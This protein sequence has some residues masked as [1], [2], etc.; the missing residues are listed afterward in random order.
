MSSQKAI[1]ISHAW[2]GISDEI[3]AELTRVLKQEDISF[4]LDKRDLG[5]RQSINDFMLEL[6][7]ADM[8]IIILSNKYLKS[9]YCM[10]ELIQIY[11]NQ[12]VRERIFPIVLD[13]VKISSSAD[14]LEFV[15]YWEDQLTNLQNKVK[16]LN[17]LSYIEGITDDLNLYTEIRNNI[18]RLT[19]ILRDINTL[20][21]TIHVESDYRDLI[22]SI[23]KK[24]SGEKDENKIFIS[25]TKTPS[26]VFNTF[27]YKLAGI[28]MLVFIALFV[29]WK[30]LSRPK[31]L[32]TAEDTYQHQQ[33]SGLVQKNPTVQSPIT[34][35]HS[36]SSERDILNTMDTSRIIKMLLNNI[37]GQG[38]LS[39]EDL[40]ALYRDEPVVTT[41]QT[42]TK[43]NKEPSHTSTEK[44]ST[45]NTYS[46]TTTSKK[47]MP[48]EKPTVERDYN[49]PPDNSPKYE[50]PVKEEKPEEK[51]HII[52][53]PTEQEP[54]KTSKSLKAF[55]LVKGTALEAR[56]SGTISSD[57]ALAVPRRINF[58]LDQDVYD[59]RSIA[60]PAGSTIVGTL[61]SVKQSDHKRAGSITMF[62]DYLV[63]PDGQKIPLQK[64]EMYLVA[65]GKV[66]YEIHPN[67][68]IKTKTGSSIQIKY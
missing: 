41:Q 53:I 17:S 4:I 13:E 29:T 49:K 45:P 67:N 3:L 38:Q 7:K 35:P 31:D 60:I 14:R 25:S 20:N 32:I 16:E 5:Y 6:G 40:D 33:D 19:G 62:L 55:T 58:I 28:S 59:G 66:P 12:N 64:E 10:F 54:A 48:I 63:A 8:V 24:I 30:I 57:D 39:Q 15:K 21:V 23:K 65:S 47:Q 26:P 44:Y 61:S 2:G 1:F 18:A 56:S 43:E 46:T 36:G 51:T 11:K 22:Q 52:T 37:G 50:P 9:E 34:N 42:G 27:N 68:K